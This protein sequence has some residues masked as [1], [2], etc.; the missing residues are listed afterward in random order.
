MPISDKSLKERSKLQASPPRGYAA[1][2][3]WGNFK[4]AQAFLPV[5]A[6]QFTAET[7]VLLFSL[8][9]NPSI[10]ATPLYST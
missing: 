8:F 5:L 3:R 2:K 9:Q 6:V 10:G 7:A 1:K 4:V